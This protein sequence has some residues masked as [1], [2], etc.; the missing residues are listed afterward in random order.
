M[1]GATILLLVCAIASVWATPLMEIDTREDL[2]DL[3]Y[4]ATFLG[5]GGG[6]PFAMGHAMVE[7][8]DP[9]M[10]R[11][12]D[13]AEAATSGW[14]TVVAGIGSP[15][16]AE[17]GHMDFHR[18]SERALGLL[19]QFSGHE[20]S[21][22]VPAETGGANTIMPLYVAYL[23]NRSGS[24]MAVVD[25][26]GAGRAVPAL[27]MVTLAAF[28]VPFDYTV[29]SNSDTSASGECDVIFRNTEPDTVDNLIRGTLGSG[30]MGGSAVL[31]TWSVDSAS[32]DRALIPGTLTTALAVGSLLRSNGYSIDEL[33][34]FLNSDAYLPGTT[35]TKA[36]LLFTGTIESFTEETSGGFDFGTMVLHA[37]DGSEMRIA[38]QNENLIA[39]LDSSDTPAVI[40]PDLICFVT[41]D[42]LPFSN[43]EVQQV[44]TAGSTVH[45]VGIR[46]HDL[47]RNDHTVEAF[48]E[49]IRRTGY[50]G[51]YV[52]VEELER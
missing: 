6:G 39:W 38:S 37:D 13:T 2:L 5:S 26:D 9:T 46:A 4:G 40:G 29:I 24:D 11:I 20:Y 19:G 44:R 8:I 12:I 1:R 28:D 15:D 14:G 10:I 42:G 30:S 50:G 22:L 48:M 51:P 23:L 52:P 35:G 18:A 34:D 32:V 25:A 33:L 45:V 17:G 41:E 16:A 36:W 3:L 7:E 27:G 47:L 43:A 31:A 21:Y 49:V